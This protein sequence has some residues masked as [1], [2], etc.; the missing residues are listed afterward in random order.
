MDVHEILQ[1]LLMMLPQQ[2]WSI[3]M[4][5]RLAERAAGVSTGKRLQR[6]PEDSTALPQLEV[7]K[8]GEETPQARACQSARWQTRH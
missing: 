4:M 1:M 6:G 5:K 2:A 3:V 8:V 7:Y